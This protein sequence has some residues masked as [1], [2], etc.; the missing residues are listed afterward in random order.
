MLSWL[1]DKAEGEETSVRNLALRIL[2]I[3]LA[4]IHTMTLV[5]VA[6]TQKML[7]YVR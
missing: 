2:A 5:C 7:F 4:A 6:S 3:Y 1:I